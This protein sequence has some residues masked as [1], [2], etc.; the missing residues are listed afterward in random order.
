MKAKKTLFLFSLT[1]ALL[2]VVLVLPSV[3]QAKKAEGTIV[4]A[5][6]PFYPPCEMLKSHKIVGFD[7][8]LVAAIGR[9]ISYNVEFQ[10]CPWDDIIDGVDEPFDM[11]ASSITITEGRE[12]S[13]DF[14]DPYVNGNE[15][16]TVAA[17]S[18]IASTDDL[19]DGNRIAVGLGYVGDL[20]A[21][22]E[23][24]PR[25]VVVE[26]YEDIMDAFEALKA[27]TVD[28]VIFEIPMTHYILFQDPGLNAKIV[29]EIDGAP[30]I[31]EDLRAFAFPKGSALV[32][33][34]N[35]GLQEVIDD[36]TYAK[37]YRKWFGVEP[38]PLP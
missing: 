3:A 33:V 35:G 31:G 18:A 28:G 25:G 14:S 7:I 10:S 2:T 13:M 21:T 1:L 37:I 6:D 12:L 5:T 29:E 24:G 36:G 23:L 19:G 34:V 15:G 20:W 8:D 11:A 4:V 9:R 26:R 38:W 16:L 27:G 22:G 17:D 32:E 30:Y